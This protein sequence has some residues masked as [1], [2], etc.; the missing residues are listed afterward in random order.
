MQEIFSV[1]NELIKKYSKLKQKKFRS[2]FGLFLIEGAKCVQD[3][4][5]YGIEI[6]HIFVLKNKA[7]KFNYPNLIITDE[8][9]M[10]K[11]ADTE[12]VPEIIATGKIPQVKFDGKKYNK[13]A[14]FENIKDGG[15]LGTIIRSAC[16]F[17][18]DA[19]ILTGDCIDIYNPK[20]VRSSVGN[21]FKIPVIKIETNKLAEKLK[22]FKLY[23]TVVKGGR[24][25]EEIKFKDKSAVLFGS[26][27][28]G[29]SRELKDKADEHITLKMADNVESL[30]LAVSAAIVFYKML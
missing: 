2:E 19:I 7:D 1:N 4:I 10:K 13:I 29:I 21:I 11:I 20:V 6:E 5:L 18:L 3:A 16:A 28:D 27:A 17:S 22:D 26:E 14:V 9:V 24:D 15:N 12:S 30:N 23:S 8:K 25:L